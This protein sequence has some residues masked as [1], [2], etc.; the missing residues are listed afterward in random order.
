MY[1]HTRD[2]LPFFILKYT[3][4]HGHKRRGTKKYVKYEKVYLA[5]FSPKNNIYI[6]IFV[7]IRVFFN[8]LI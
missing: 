8:T 3:L 1:I 5:F 6:C 4:K 7:I 2:S